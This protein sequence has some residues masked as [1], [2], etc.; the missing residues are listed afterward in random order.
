MGT[1]Q[2][3]SYGMNVNGNNWL[4]PSNMYISPVMM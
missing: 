4:N 1:N 3:D 2:R